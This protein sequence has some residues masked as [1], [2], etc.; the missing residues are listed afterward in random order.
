MILCPHCGSDKIFNAGDNQLG[1][2]CGERFLPG[3]KPYTLRSCEHVYMGKEYKQKRKGA[4]RGTCSNCERP[5]LFM[6]SGDLCGACIS[7]VN[8]VHGPKLTK[9][10]PQYKRALREYREMKW[11]ERF[12]RKAA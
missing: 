8:G 3:Y 9:G 5:N 12:K 4:K 7:H 10:S 1:C 6:M 11:P 2:L